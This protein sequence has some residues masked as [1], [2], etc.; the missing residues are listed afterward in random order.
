M[1]EEER[2]ESMRCAVREGER[3]ERESMARRDRRDERR[4]EK[5]RERGRE[6][7]L[8]VEEAIACAKRPRVQR[9]CR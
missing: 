6:E 2:E 8:R 1:R 5:M 9:C 3:R 7:R 4:A